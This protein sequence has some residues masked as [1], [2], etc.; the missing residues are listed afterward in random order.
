[1][2]IHEKQLPIRDDPFE[3]LE[4]IVDTFADLNREARGLIDRYLAGLRLD[5]TDRQL[6]S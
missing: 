1:M 4:E 2:D 6:A 5:D 3:R